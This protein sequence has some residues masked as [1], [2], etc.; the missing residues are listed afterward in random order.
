MKDQH[1]FSPTTCYILLAILFLIAFAER[2][3]FDLGPN[4]ELVTTA[5]ILSS[6]Y[7]GKKESFLLVFF[8]M[9]FSDFIIGNTNIFIF[10]WSGFLIPALFSTNLINRISYSINNLSLKTRNLL[11]SKSF[12]KNKSQSQITSKI[13]TF[14]SLTLSGLISNLFFFF[15]TNFGV[16]L[17]DSWNMYPNS[18]QGLIMAYINAL[19]FLKYQTLSTLL[20]LPNGFLLTETF[21]FFYKN[22]S[23]IQTRNFQPTPDKA[24]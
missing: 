24:R 20:L 19:P 7:F 9:L 13:F 18:F 16:W 15:W 11:L 6:F 3:F 10:T 17:L 14:L 8:I 1:K 2:V 21:I 12:P 4:F 5:L 22:I 23:P